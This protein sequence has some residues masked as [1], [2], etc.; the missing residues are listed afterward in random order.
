[1]HMTVEVIS[2]RQFDVNLKQIILYV[3]YFKFLYTF[4]SN[5]MMLPSIVFGREKIKVSVKII[6]FYH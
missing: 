2:M 3:T 1:V 5:R 4:I 6:I